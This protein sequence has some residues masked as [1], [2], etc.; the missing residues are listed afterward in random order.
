M[1]VFPESCKFR[2]SSLDRDSPGYEALEN[3]KEYV[4]N[5]WLENDNL[6]PRQLW[7][8]YKKFGVRTTNHL[9]GYH[10][11]I[12]TLARKRHLNIFEMVKCLQQIEARYKIVMLQ[13][14]MGQAAPQKCS[15]YEKINRRMMK[16][17]E[18]L[19]SGEISLQQYLRRLGPNL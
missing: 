17:V 3:F 4:I 14:R 16:L 11:A 12:N 13:L 15:K 19:E 9:E 8:H 1:Q 6:F 7:N 10:H 18:E 2:N 5:T